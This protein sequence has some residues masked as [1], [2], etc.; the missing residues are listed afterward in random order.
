M[1]IKNCLKI[2]LLGL[3]T[4]LIAACPVDKGQYPQNAENVQWKLPFFQP[5]TVWQAMS[6]DFKLK[7]ENIHHLAVQREIHW[8]RHRQEY[9]HELTRNANPYLYYVY[10]ETKQRGL[11]AEIALLPM[12]ESNYNPF[13]YSKR[14]ATGLW[15]MMP[16]TASGFG[17]KINWWVDDRRNI[18]DSTKAALNY[19]TYLHDFFGNW[20]LAIAAYDSG[21]GTVQAAIRYNLRHHRPTDFWSLPLPKETKEYVPKLLALA[22]IISHPKQYHLKLDKVADTP[23]F[24][25]VDLHG[26]LAINQIAKYADSTPKE[27]R[28]LNPA[29]RRWATMPHVSY[30]ILLPADKLALFQQH[31][32][33][34]QHH[35]VTWLHHKVQHG[36]SMSLIARHYHTSVSALYQVNN[37]KTQTLQIGQNLLIPR[38]MQHATLHRP[39]KAQSRI[40]E[41]S[42]PGPKRF[43]HIVK[44][45]E[46]LWTVAERYG[47]KP[48]EI[49]YWNKLAYRAT[50]HVGQKLL[51]WER[52]SIFRH[53]VRPGESLWTIARQYHIT[54][55]KLTSW[56]HLTEKSVLHVGQSLVIYR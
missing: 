19:L 11:P 10:Q 2:C 15:Q 29:F 42:I 45:R 53:Q 26:Q 3:V 25:P 46:T 33:D 6:G 40:A 5:D 36:E 4:I 30:A 47:I 39:S 7:Q 31:Y 13:L 20:L 21:E 28:K 34:S 37:L 56:N 50:L 38:S 1:H 16:G 14:G 24:K 32:Y 51:I 52:Q 54:I 22:A 23:Y 55:S 17:I 44:P 18:I 12:I 27:I 48:S 41:D 49:R 8:F 35:H 9:I 43:V